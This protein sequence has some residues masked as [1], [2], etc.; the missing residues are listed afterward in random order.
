MNWKIKSAVQRACAH[1]PVG[2]QTIYRQLQRYCG[3]LVNGYDYSFLLSEAARMAALLHSVGYEVEGASVMEVGTGWRVDIPIGLYLCGARR[4][5]T[6]DLNRYLIEPLSLKTVRYVHDNMEKIRKIFSA[7]APDLLEARLM[8]LRGVSTME[9]L[10]AVAGIEYYA[11]CNCACT[12]FPDR[13]IDVQYSY[14]VFEHVPLST[15]E[16]ILPES[17]RLLSERGIAYHHIDVSDHFAQV[18]PS[19]TMVNFLQF[20]DEDWQ[21]YAGTSWSYHNRLREDDYRELLQRTR[22]EIVYWKT[23]VDDRSLECIKNG[24]PLAPQYHNRPPEVLSTDI[25]DV[26]SRPA[27]ARTTSFDPTRSS[28]MRITQ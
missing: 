23:H 7:V 4:I 26:V 8:A 15:L 27:E 13:S 16:A 2:K 25:V 24:F 22:H 28:G 6:C 19:I 18:D 1:V 5:I 9:E 10:F 3:G 12:G 14:T 17:N 21:R 11:P 20:S